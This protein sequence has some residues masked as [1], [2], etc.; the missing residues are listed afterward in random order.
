MIARRRDR[1]DRASGYL[2][3]DPPSALEVNEIARAL[4]PRRQMDLPPPPR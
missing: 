3:F 1:G 2:A 4:K